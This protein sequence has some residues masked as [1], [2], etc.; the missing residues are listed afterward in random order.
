VVDA[1]ADPT[2]PTSRGTAADRDDQVGV[3]RGKGA[4]PSCTFFSIGLP[5]ASSRSAVSI[6]AVCS[7]SSIG[8][9]VPCLTTP[10]SVTI[11][12]AGAEARNLFADLVGGAHAVKDPRRKA[13]I[14]VPARM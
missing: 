8:A 14:L 7:D 5:G 6:P 1:E 3:V 4:T 12:R 10:L 9:T 13:Q 11:Q 2:Y